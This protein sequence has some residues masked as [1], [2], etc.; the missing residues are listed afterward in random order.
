MT[1]L[2]DTPPSDAVTA[3]PVRHR[4]AHPQRWGLGALLGVTAALY[5]WNLSINGYA[6]SF[7]SAAMQA[8][9][10]S[11]KAWFFGSSDAANSITVDKP[12]MSLWLP[13]IAIRI[14]GLNSWSILVP[15][16]L[17]GVA[18]VA[19]LY[20]V[21]KRQVGWQAG[22][23]AGAVLALTPVAALMFRFNNPDALLVLLMIA[24]VWAT[25]RGIED[26]RI[27]WMLLT[28]MFV[29]FGFLTKQLQ[30]FLVIPPLAVAYLAFGQH[31]WIKR[32]GHLFAA[33]GA[34]IVSAGWWVLAVTLW[35]KDS[36][37]YIG[38]SQHNSILELT[39]GYNGFGRLTGN[40]TGSTGG[41][42]RA[43]AFAEFL[44]SRGAVGGPG[45]PGGRGGMWGETGFFRMFQPEQGGQIA[46]LI[47][48]ALLLGVAAVVLTWRAPRTSPIRA[49]IVV[50]GVWLLTTAAVFSYMSGI[51][52]SYYT[53]A[54]APAIAGLLAAGG[55]VCWRQR[56]LL[57][58][59]AVLAAASVTTGVMAYLLLNRS[60][61]FVPWLRWVVVVGAVI[62]AVGLLVPGVRR[63]GPVTGVAAAVAIIAGLAGPTAYVVDTL[64][65]SKQGSIITAGPQVNGGGFGGPGGLRRGAFGPR[66]GPGVGP[67][68]NGF[69]P[70]G[71]VPGQ[72]P[73]QGIP[74]AAGTPVQNQRGFT[75]GGPGGNLLMGSRPTAEMV[76][77]LERNSGSYTWVAAAVGSNE[78]S[79]YQLATQKPVM[80]IG[81]FNGSDP[82]PTLAQ[83]Q[84]YVR[85]G[86]IHYFIGGGRLGG[87]MNAQSTATA[88]SEWVQANYSAITVG[89]VTLYDLTAPVT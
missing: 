23:L 4:I 28:G 10:V 40:E 65:T 26:G 53:I 31:T 69:G 74:G 81:G 1:S 36:R 76:S 42:P 52:H 57:W 17:M 78:A 77:L 72:G 48:T 79:G 29:G 41:G 34:L 3:P 55:V 16:V 30:V 67:G 87:G 49:L 43:G 27:R 19:L 25:M 7:Y 84:K 11:W 80:P 68:Q 15:Q 46:W 73:G 8:G 50:M 62:A 2:L 20:L 82:S 24:A 89:S 38:G 6:N 56:E 59:R 5:L 71:A 39:L 61:D 70:G 83:F 12:P 51:F 9:S 86:K 32:M 44:S 58:V 33:L 37:P 21:I 14:F 60:P 75:A 35:P 63:T 85:E 47:P 18:S 13:S 66:L 45:R 54:L 88:I 64:H 22:L